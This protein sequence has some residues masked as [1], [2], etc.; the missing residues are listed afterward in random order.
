[1]IFDTC[2]P[3]TQRAAFSAD[4]IVEMEERKGGRKECR[5]RRLVKVVFCSNSHIK[6]NPASAKAISYFA[7]R[8]YN[9]SPKKKNRTN[10]PMHSKF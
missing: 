2:I 4:G 3:K 7:T 1:M 9:H 6:Y 5:D 10:S 8:P